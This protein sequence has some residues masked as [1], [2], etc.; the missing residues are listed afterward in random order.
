MFNFAS[1]H[2]VSIIQKKGA[3]NW[4]AEDDPEDAEEI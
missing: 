2:L 1:F 4:L 3:L